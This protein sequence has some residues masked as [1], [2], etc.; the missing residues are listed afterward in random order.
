[1]D[2]SIK[3]N[4]C[5]HIHLVARSLCSKTDDSPLEMY[6][7]GDLKI[8]IDDNTNLKEEVLKEISCDK[9]NTPND[10]ARTK[11]IYEK[12]DILMEY[13]TR[14]T[15]TSDQKEYIDKHFTQ[16]LTTLEA[17]ATTAQIPVKEEE[18]NRQPGNSNIT[19]QRSYVSTKK[20]KKS[21]QRS[22]TEEKKLEIC[23]DLSLLSDN[24][25]LQ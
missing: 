4:M 6:E 20:K 22:L 12:N 18:C 8:D 9:I 23:L 1:M 25:R 17:M 10:E 2:N 3:N 24:G 13:M 14:K 7:T 19:K 16:M 21:S 11:R 5:K 15:T